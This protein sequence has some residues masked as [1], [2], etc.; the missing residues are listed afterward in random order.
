MPKSNK[1][2]ICYSC[3]NEVDPKN[4]YCYG[5]KRHVCVECALKF[6]HFPGGEYHE[7]KGIVPDSR[8]LQPIDCQSDA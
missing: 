6:G 5:C 4:D 3:S 8:I 7:K 1:K 2:V